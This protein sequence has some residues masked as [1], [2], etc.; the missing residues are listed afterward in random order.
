MERLGFLIAAVAVTAVAALYDWRK[1]EIPNWVTIGPFGVALLAHA[2]LGGLSQGWRGAGWALLGA[3]LGAIACGLVPAL[4]WWKGAIGGGDLKL[5]IALG[6]LLGPMLGIE[7][8]LYGF[9]AA[10]LYAPARLAYEGKL[11]RTLG[12]TAALAFNPVLPK[13]KRR[14]IAP[15]MMTW[16]RFGPPMFVGM[17]VTVLLNWGA[18]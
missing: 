13:S 9:V 11:M 6:A 10:A 17:C 1:G 8:E 12:N 5:L 14:D 15:E 16:L 2:V 4:L 7:A 18:P 3:L